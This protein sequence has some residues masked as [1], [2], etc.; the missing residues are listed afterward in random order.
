MSKGLDRKKNEK[1]KPQK[2]LMEKRAAKR[3]KKENRGMLSIAPLP[4]AR[5]R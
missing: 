1:K 3:A 4:I 2:T 5:K